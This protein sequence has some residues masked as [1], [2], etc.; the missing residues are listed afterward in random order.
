MENN[1]KFSLL[2]DA[3]HCN[4]LLE[5][6]KSLKCDQDYH[7]YQGTGQKLAPMN[8]CEWEERKNML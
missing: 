1:S 2:N 3:R 7:C 8:E 5:E 6:L 4:N